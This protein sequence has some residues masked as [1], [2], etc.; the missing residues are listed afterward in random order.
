M[1]TTTQK[2]ESVRH[3]KLSEK[4]YQQAW[5]GKHPSK[6]KPLVPYDP[7]R[8]ARDGRKAAA[9]DKD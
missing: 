2:Q 9:N 8:N 4:I 6:L 5:V 1:I 7:T 3:D